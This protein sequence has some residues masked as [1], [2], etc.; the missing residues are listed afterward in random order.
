MSSWSHIGFALFLLGTSLSLLGQVDEGVQDTLTLEEVSVSVLPFQQSYRE[1]A[2]GVFLLKPEAVDLKLMVTSTELFNMAPGVYM[3][4]GT[5]STSRLVIRGVGSRTPY[6]TNRIRAYLDDIPLTSGDGVSTLEDQDISALGRLEILKGPASSLYGAGLGGVVRLN[7]L[8]PKSNGFSAA[9]SGELGSFGIGRFGLTTA[10]KRKK[11]AVT[12]GVTRSVSEGY[13]DNSNYSRTNVFTNL[14]WFGAKN[15]LTFTFSLVDL[16][17]QIPSSL[18]ETDYLEEPWKAG[19]SW[20]TI[21]GFEE[22]IKVLGGLSLESRL[23]KRLSNKVVLFSS[24]SDPYESRPFNILDDQSTSIGFREVLEYRTESWKFSGGLEYFH[25]WVDWK[26]FETDQGN[27]SSLLTHQGEVRQQMNAFSMAQWRP[28][29]KL[30]VDGGINL[31]LISYSL[32]TE[33]RVDSSDQSGQYAY[34]PVFSPRLGISYQHHNSQSLYASVGHGFSAPS[35]EETLLP[36]GSINTELRPEIGWNFELG[37]RGQLWNDRFNYDATLY[38]VLLDDLLV[39]ERIA[40]DIFTGANAGQALNT[41]IELWADALLLQSYE[42]KA[43]FSYTLSHNQFLEFEDDGINYK[44]NSLPGIPSQILNAILSAK[45]D[46]L[47]IKLQYQ[48]S[49]KQ[50]MDDLNSELYDGHHLLHMQASWRIRIKESPFH[51]QLN[52]GIRNILNSRYASMILV[53]A[54]S[55]GGNA[56][57]YY[58]PGNPRQFHLGASFH[59]R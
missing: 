13:R 19:G 35:L 27:Q 4:S 6:N 33:F 31:N 59:F 8:Y 10:Y 42:V 20:G 37:D 48:F 3:A 1:S 28:N 50:W 32:Q 34:Q 44:G 43:T 49:G 2:G 39:T 56:P 12:G 17:A 47:A 53:N 9:I 52:G 57:R 11:L 22:Y 38:A 46:P 29:K 21:Q 5:Y 45:W 14:K 30:L 55:F 40:E 41:G 25:E 23:G 18:N 24:Y 51:I 54:P 58:Y 26:I 16:H 15:I 7:S 36:E